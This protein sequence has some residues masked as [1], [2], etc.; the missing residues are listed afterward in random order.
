MELINKGL[1]NLICYFCGEQIIEPRGFFRESLCMHH[2]NYEHPEL[3]PAHVHCHKTW[4]KR[5]DF[6]LRVMKNEY[7]KYIQNSGKEI[8]CYYCGKA[9]TKFK[10]R[11][12][13]SLVVHHING[14]HDDWQF[15][16]LTTSHY[17][18][19]SKYIDFGDRVGKKNGFYGKHHTENFKK[20][21]SKAKKGI[22]KKDNPNL[23]GGA[24]IGRIAWNKGLTKETDERVLLLSE[25][26]KNG[27]SSWKVRREKYGPSGGNSNNGSPKIWAVRRERYGPSG[28]RINK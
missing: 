20:I 22:T 11:D 27:K 13:D 24:K 2:I 17:G 23:R 1:K 15:E 16:N 10:R 3:V 5:N 4:H 28:M 19:H 18:C 7:F 25:H 14:N 21:L 9:I 8:S 6:P 12:S 26:I